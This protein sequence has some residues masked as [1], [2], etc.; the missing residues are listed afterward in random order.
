[1]PLYHIL[2]E[3]KLMGAYMHTI[4]AKCPESALN[5]LS[6]DERNL[7]KY[8]IEDSTGNKIPIIKGKLKCG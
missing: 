6:Q 4:Q 5:T 2:S 1:M 8:L 3:S 7:S